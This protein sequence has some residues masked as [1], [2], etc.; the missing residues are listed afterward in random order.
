MNNFLSL[1]RWQNGNK[2]DFEPGEQKEGALL[3][4]SRLSSSVM[5]L[6]LVVCW[7]KTCT[8]KKVVLKLSP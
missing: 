5:D 3:D 2:D 4:W 6:L 1:G 8:L 7:L